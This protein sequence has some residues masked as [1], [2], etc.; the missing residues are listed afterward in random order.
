MSFCISYVILTLNIVS[1]KPQEFQDLLIR[2]VSQNLGYSKG[3]PVA[4]SVIYK[5]LLH[6]R[7]FE[8]EKTSIFDRIIQTISSAIGVHIFFEKLTRAFVFVL[9]WPHSCFGFSLFQAQD[10]NDMLAYWLSNTSSLL[11][12]LQQTLKASGAAGFTPQRR[13][14]A[15]TSIFGRMSSV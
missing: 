13:R 9:I 8:V 1:S 7:S 11:L 3:K 4:A 15:A 10:S 12:L 6:W 5:C 2:C 14:A